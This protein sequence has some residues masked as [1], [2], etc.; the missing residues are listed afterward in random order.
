MSNGNLSNIEVETLH[1]ADASLFIAK[2]DLGMMLLG[3]KKLPEL[4]KSGEAKLEGDA[5]VFGKLFS[6]LA[7]ADPNFEI[8]PLPVNSN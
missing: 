1:P 7:V 2:K 4:L 3:I 5:S 8:V 6:S